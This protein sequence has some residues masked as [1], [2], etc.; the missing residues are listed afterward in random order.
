MTDQ[1]MKEFMDDDDAMLDMA[2]ILYHNLEEVERKEYR[3]NLIET[4][5]MTEEHA[6][7]M[8]GELEDRHKKFKK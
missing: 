1:E 2:A 8:I 4:T 3:R 7:N 5:G 6:D